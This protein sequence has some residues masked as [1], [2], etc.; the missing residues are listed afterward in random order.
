MDDEPNIRELLAQTL[1]LVG[2]EVVTADCGEA[3]VT[4][5]AS[6][7]ALVVLDVKLPDFDGFEVARRLRAHKRDARSSS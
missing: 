5:A 2:F 4:A 7:P 3:A 1:R 6:G